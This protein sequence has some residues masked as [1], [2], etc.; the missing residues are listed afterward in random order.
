MYYDA[1][2]IGDEDE[3]VISI[4]RRDCD[5]RVTE[6]AMALLNRHQAVIIDLEAGTL[7]TAR[8]EAMLITEIKDKQR[9]RSHDCC[10][11]VPAIKGYSDEA[12]DGTRVKVNRGGA[13]II[14]KDRERYI[15]C[16]HCYHANPVSRVTCI[17]CTE[18]LWAGLEQRL[19]DMNR[20]LRYALKNH[21]GMTSAATRHQISLI[22]VNLPPEER[23][24][25]RLTEFGTAMRTIYK[26]A[27]DEA[28]EMEGRG[29]EGEEE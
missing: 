19:Y 26:S 20:R 22:M 13:V 11:G 25:W 3:R 23:G 15:V 6:A 10:D 4:H 8:M 5:G 17:N 29:D 27:L 12:R 28:T 24:K 1:V 18:N 16:A 9:I 7:L 2:V 21:D 14:D